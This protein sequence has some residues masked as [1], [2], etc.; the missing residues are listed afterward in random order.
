LL[1]SQD[2]FRAH[3]FWRF[4][5]LL[6]VDLLPGLLLGFSGPITFLRASFLLSFL[7]S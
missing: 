3:R 7:I 2:I 6:W 4:E 1:C 5:H